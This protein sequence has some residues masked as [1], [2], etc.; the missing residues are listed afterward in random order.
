VLQALKIDPA[1]AQGT[2]TMTLGWDLTDEDIAYVI[3]T[4]P[5][6]VAQLRDLSPLYSHFKKTGE[7]KI[8][9]PKLNSHNK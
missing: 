5:P 6:I 8:A 2:I 4:L 9:G 3:A 7:R 1:V